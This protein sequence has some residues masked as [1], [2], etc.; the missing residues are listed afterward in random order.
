MKIFSSLFNYQNESCKRTTHG[1][2]QYGRV[3]GTTRATEL[4]AVNQH[5]DNINKI[6]KLA[7]RVKSKTRKPESNQLMRL[8]DT[9][10]S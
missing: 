9:L 1:T 6:V 5:V 3:Y 4:R 8:A 2:T 7:K 10:S